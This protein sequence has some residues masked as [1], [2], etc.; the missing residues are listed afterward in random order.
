MRIPSKHLKGMT[1]DEYLRSINAEYTET[2]VN[3]AVFEKPKKAVEPE[4]P[5]AKKRTKPLATK[6]CVLDPSGSLRIVVAVVTHSEGNAK[7]WKARH[8]RTGQAWMAV[9]D[10]V[11]RELLAPFST[12]YRAGQPLSIKFVRLGGKHID[13]MANLGMTMKG[14]E[15]AL[16]FLIGANDGSPNWVAAAQQE[17]DLPFLGVRIE[18]TKA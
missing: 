9:S 1:P 5:E 13:G 10:A 16:A 7:E 11:D 18:I 17:E 2:T 14:C 15:D 12:Y 3:L 6:V 4:E 8:R